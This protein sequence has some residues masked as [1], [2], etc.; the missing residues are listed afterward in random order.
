MNSFGQDVRYAVRVLLGKPGFSL[1]V[2]LTLALGI[3]ANT[4]VFSFVNSF[5]MRPL[6]ADE[7]DELV[8]VYQ[9]SDSGR[10]FSTFSYPNYVDLR[11][12]G[13]GLV[14]LVA[15]QVRERGRTHGR[16]R[17]RGAG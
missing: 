7:P 10:R 14:G 8:R 2:I 5:F 1:T 6:P 3:G 15:H 17:R 13:T 9:F 4:A 16:K 11:D 12:R